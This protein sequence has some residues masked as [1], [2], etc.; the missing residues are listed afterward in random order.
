MQRKCSDKFFYFVLKNSLKMRANGE[1]I[2]NSRTRATV[3]MLTGKWETMTVKPP[4]HGHRNMFLLFLQ[5]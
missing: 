3:K 4:N 5:R 1:G 2:E